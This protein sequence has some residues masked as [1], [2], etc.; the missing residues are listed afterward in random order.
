MNPVISVVVPCYNEEAVLPLFAE[1]V[2]AVLDALGL[3]YEVILVDDGSTDRTGQVAREICQRHER[4]RVVSLFRNFGHQNAVS[5][6]LDYAHGDGVVLIDADLQDPPEVIPEMV[7]RWREG[8]HVVYGQRRV[9]EGESWFKRQ[10]ASLFYRLMRWMSHARIARDTGD[11]RLMD[12]GVVDVLRAMPERH[13]FIRGM[14]SWIGGRQVA[15]LYDRKAREA[16][17]TKYSFRKMFLFATDAITGFSVLPLRFV[18]GL[19]AITVCLSLLYAAFIIVVRL[20]APAYYVPGWPT[21]AVL[22]LFFGGLNMFCVGLVG[23]YVGRIYEEVKGRPRYV[24]GSVFPPDTPLAAAAPR[25]T[26]TDHV[27]H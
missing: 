5:A 15:V 17:E 21:T 22:I 3:S 25:L 14:V 8:F 9:R 24:V 1:R 27:R 4:F 7:G 26:T 19:G 13:R 2:R 18:T 12:R 23:E 10:S 6:G 16:G 20:F 11:F